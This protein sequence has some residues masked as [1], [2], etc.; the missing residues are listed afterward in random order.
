M[1]FLYRPRETWMP[2]ALPRSRTDQAAYNRRLQADFASTR[3][4]TPPVPAAE[5]DLIGQLKELA[6]LRETGVLTDAEFD[7]AKAALLSG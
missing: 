3:R 2:F 6:E 5:P 4:V 1:L 7:S